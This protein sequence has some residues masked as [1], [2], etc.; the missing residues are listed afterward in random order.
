MPEHLHLSFRIRSC[1]I[2][3][4]L[5]GF[6]DGSQ[7]NRC[8]PKAR[9][10]NELC[11]DCSKHHEI[12]DF[13]KNCMIPK[14]SFQFLELREFIASGL[15]SKCCKDWQRQAPPAASSSSHTTANFG[16]GLANA[17]RLRLSR[18]C[19]GSALGVRAG[20]VS[21]TSSLISLSS[22]SI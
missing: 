20:Q 13:D 11:C 12:T 19:L 6:I 2:T 4:R 10:S 18:F 22:L 16:P 14:T 17:L 3:R 15:T 9:Q 21:P 7:S 5:V 1:F 8:P